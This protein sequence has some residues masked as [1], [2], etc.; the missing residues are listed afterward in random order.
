MKIFDTPPKEGMPVRHPSFFKALLRMA[1]A[2][3]T[4]CVDNGRVTWTNGVP[5]IIIDGAVVGESGGGETGGITTDHVW[6][7]RQKLEIP[8]EDKTD[9]LKIYF[10]G[11]TPEWVE[12]MP[13]LVQDEDAEVY[14]VTANRIHLPGN[15]AQGL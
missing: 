2:W 7:G 1:K 11:R 4:L 8:Q 9:F 14:D 13:E 12:S 3:E 15:F 6:I 5:K 10:D